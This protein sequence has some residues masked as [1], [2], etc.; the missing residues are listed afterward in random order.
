ML[1]LI[2]QSLELKN[3]VLGV[4]LFF[5]LLI[6]IAFLKPSSGISIHFDFFIPID[7][8]IH[9]SIHFVLLFIW[10]YY[11][12]LHNNKVLNLKLIMITVLSCFV[13]GII[14]EILQGLLV[15]SRQADL[16]DVIANLIGTL[17]GLLIFVN[18]KFRF[19]S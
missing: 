1:M 2:N 4:S 13:Y 10:M 8:L 5:T 19:N 15:V 6:T 16:L 12:F 9:A 18:V 14:I 3:K 11:A 17:L 7:K